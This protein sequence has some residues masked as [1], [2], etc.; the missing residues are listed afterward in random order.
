MI[1][2]CGQSQRHKAQVSTR[3]CLS[4]IS[5]TDPCVLAN[6]L[7]WVW[8]IPLLLLVS[9]SQTQMPPPCTENK[10]LSSG[11]EYLYKIMKKKKPR[12]HQSNSREGTTHSDLL[13]PQH[14]TGTPMA[15]PF[16][17]L[18]MQKYAETQRFSYSDKQ[19]CT[20]QKK[21][22]HFLNCPANYQQF[23]LLRGSS[24]RRLQEH[25]FYSPLHSQG[26]NIPSLQIRRFKNSTSR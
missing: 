8:N 5:S 26:R 4:I 14:G 12:R 10:H 18:F 11:L 2:F 1:K 17:L 16:L 6:H 23:L 24:S 7:L 15:A 19:E 25:R 9:N 22:P 3:C 20:P 21:A 13:L